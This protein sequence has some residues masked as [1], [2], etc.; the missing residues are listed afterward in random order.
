MSGPRFV[1]NLRA[2]AIAILWLGL[3]F[4]APAQ[5]GRLSDATSPYLLLHADDAI[6]WHPWGEQALERARE[7]NKLIFLSLGYASCHWCHVLART[8]FADQRVVETLNQHFISILVDQEERPDLDNYFTNIMLAM[9]GLSGSPANFVL[10]PDLV[11]LFA[12]GYLAPEPEYGS[13]GFVAV[14]QTLVKEWTENR[15]G[16]LKDAEMIRG[17]LQSLAEPV[18]MGAAHGREDPR[19]SAARAW[20]GAFDD[21]YGGFGRDSKFLHPPRQSSWRYRSSS[22]PL[23]HGTDQSEQGLF[24]T[25][26]TSLSSPAGGTYMS[27]IYNWKHPALMQIKAPADVRIG[28]KLTAPRGCSSLGGGTGYNFYQLW[29]LGNV[30]LV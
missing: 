7:E 3:L 6:D 13:P 21:T 2:S 10:T 4:G 27:N 15:E 16:I 28:S 18:A 14:V 11:P 23:R 20:S 5:G 12:A 9:A 30:G 17:Q 19:D 29:H 8:T 26:S 25:W 24:Y 22:H 1:R